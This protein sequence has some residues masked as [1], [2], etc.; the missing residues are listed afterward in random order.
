MALSILTNGT[1]LENENLYC[2][3]TYLD[4][5]DMVQI[6]LDGSEEENNYTKRGGCFSE[7]SF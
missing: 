3:N 1:L 4:S 7:S 5:L 2:V 6:S